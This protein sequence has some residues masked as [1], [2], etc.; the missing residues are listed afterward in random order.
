MCAVEAGLLREKWEGVYIEFC[1]FFSVF[2]VTDEFA[3]LSSEG[4]LG[5]DE[6]WH[7]GG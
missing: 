3:P 7:I 1:R 5:F 4:Q 6:I 2:G